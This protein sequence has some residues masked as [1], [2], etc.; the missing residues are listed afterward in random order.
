M[1]ATERGVPR[2][3]APEASR[4]TRDVP[5][6]VT[7]TS[8]I[9]GVAA[10][11]AV[12]SFIDTTWMAL[13]LPAQVTLLT[14]IPLL[15]MVAVQVLADRPGQRA[16]AALCASVSVGGTWVAVFTIARLLDLPTSPLLLWPPVCV[17]LAVA[18]SHGFVWLA[19]ASV[20]G[21][22][23]GVA[24]ISFVAAGAPWITVVQRWE[25][26]LMTAVAWLVLSGR[27]AP[28]GMA[29]VRMVRRTALALLLVAVLV[30]SGLEGMS[31]L[32][33]APTS[34]LLLYQ[35]IAVPVLAA[36]AHWQ[37]RL[38]DRAGVRLVGVAFLIFLLGR[39]LDWRSTVVPAWGFFLVVALAA[40][41][42]VRR[43]GRVDGRQR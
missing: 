2:S 18:L 28:L 11:A 27:L 6:A 37:R 13:A 35:A 20:V 43:A 7:L 14:A 24:S 38:D 3:V 10:I 36:V 25:P 5:T 19:S 40:A 33:Y 4:D 31:L 1:S 29:W 32:P 42:M 16:L 30:L 39:Y 8:V 41:W 23:I 15:S 17:G 9:G 34:A 21:S 26:M 22:T 12:A